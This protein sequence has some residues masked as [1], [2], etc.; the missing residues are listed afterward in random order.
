MY[1][2]LCLSNQGT[3]FSGQVFVYNFTDALLFIS[4]NILSFG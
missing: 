1:M 2:V 3:Q 4:I